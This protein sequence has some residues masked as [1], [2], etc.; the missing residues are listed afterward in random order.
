MTINPD[1]RSPRLLFILNNDY[2][3]LGLA[4]Y[5]LQGRN[6]ASS[7]T[8]LLPP[9]LY[10]KNKD[11][12]PGTTYSYD[13]IED[14]LRTVDDTQPDIVFLFSGYILPLHQIVSL[15]ETEA[16]VQLLSDRK[17]KVVTSDPF[18]GIFS[19]LKPE[20]A[21]APQALQLFESEII[22]EQPWPYR[23]STTFG[24][25]RIL[26]QFAR[27]SHII[28]N[29]THLYYTRPDPND[30]PIEVVTDNVTFFNPSLVGDGTES[31]N[32]EVN[33]I[34][35]A[36]TEASAEK[37][38]LFILGSVDYDLQTSFYGEDKFIDLIAKK[39]EQTLQAGR[40]AVFLAPDDCIQKLR[41]R[42]PVHARK[43]LLT[44]CAYEA[45]NAHLLQAEYVFYWNLAS[46]S[47]FLRVI[48]G[49]PMF[50]FDEGHLARHVKPM[51]ERMVRWYYHNWTPP[52]L[53]QHEALDAD[54]LEELSRDYKKETAV[55]LKNFRQLPTPEQVIEE[56]FNR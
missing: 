19:H 41:S 32:S 3:E 48:N 47:T 39:V 50:M 54:A 37:H 51:H 42:A 33:A 7:T 15:E 44:F 2:G 14:I 21:N 40:R 10:S 38:W 35:S 52:S 8:L 30:E 36:D 18:F 4:M 5:F 1:T 11:T 23:L 49:L 25:M 12:L 43:D 13:S 16:L 9:R 29:T 28:R 46:Y 45:F 22:K 17:C 56:L 34:K 6:L 31:G 24:N 26:K 53:N 55:I 27:A 20:E